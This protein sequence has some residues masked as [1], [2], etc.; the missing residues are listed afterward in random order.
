MKETKT[1]TADQMRVD[2]RF[3][4]YIV[5]NR[6]TMTWKDCIK[7]IRDDCIVIYDKSRPTLGSEEIP[8]NALFEVELTAEEFNTKYREAAKGIYEILSGSEYIGDHG[9][10]EMY[11]GWIGQN[12]QWL[13]KNLQEESLQLVGWFWLSEIKHG[14]F[15]DCDIGIIAEDKDG[16]RF[17]CH[18]SKESIDQMCEMYRDHWLEN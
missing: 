16:E 6:S 5:G 8:R 14:W 12:C 11:N 10:H 18:Y 7:E 1:L 17:W 2:Q 15:D 3:E 13:Y 4:T 9:Y